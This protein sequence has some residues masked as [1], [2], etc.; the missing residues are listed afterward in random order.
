[1]GSE[2]GATV[3][4]TAIVF[5]LIAVPTL[6]GILEFGLVFKDWLTVSHASQEAAAAMSAAANDP[7]ADIAAL[8]AVADNFTGADLNRL[9]SVVIRNADTGVGTTY[10]YAPATL[11]QW[12]PC[13]DPLLPGD[14]IQPVWAPSSRNVQVNNLDRGTVEINFTHSWVTGFFGSTID[15]TRAATN[16]LEPQVFGP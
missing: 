5:A 16:Q 9:G 12:A 13:P 1:M 8:N 7:L 14:Y 6:I 11:C 10:S 4:E 2:R 3:V 15:L